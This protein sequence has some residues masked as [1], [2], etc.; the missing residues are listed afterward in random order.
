MVR[1]KD[2]CTLHDRE[3]F[4]YCDCCGLEYSSNRGDYF[5]LHPDTVM[6]CCD[7]DEPMVLVR[8]IVS[9]IPVEVSG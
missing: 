1:V 9:Y 8:K 3:T 2:L 7:C 5:N 6:K 4:L